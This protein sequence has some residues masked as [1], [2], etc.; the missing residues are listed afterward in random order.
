LNR[1]D[2]ESQATREQGDFEKS[3][4]Y[5]EVL[6]DEVVS[7]RAAVAAS[8]RYLQL[9]KVQYT[10]GL[11]DYLTVI[12]AERTLLSNQLLLSQTVNLQIAA[13]IRLIKALG[14][15]WEYHP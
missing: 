15:G 2:G 1:I 11:V 9:A 3:P 12:D 6:S 7:L 10:N 5:A 13:S 4:W 14:G 8:Q